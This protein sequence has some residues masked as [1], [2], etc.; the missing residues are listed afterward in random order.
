M[1]KHCAANR[2][3]RLSAL[4]N[5]GIY[6]YI[7]IYIYTLKFLALQGA[8]YILYY[9]YDISRLRVNDLYSSPNIVWLIKFRM[10]WA[11]H[12]GKETTGVTQA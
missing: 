3:G 6:I 10:R 5:V 8:P 11:G 12:V 9:I 1:L 2:K 4:P 7:Y